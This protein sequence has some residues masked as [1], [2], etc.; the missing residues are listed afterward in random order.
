LMVSLCTN[1]LF[2]FCNQKKDS[3]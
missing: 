2:S 3:F 1:M